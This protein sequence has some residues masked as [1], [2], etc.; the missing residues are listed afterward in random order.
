MNLK[1]V[2]LEAGH[3]NSMD[4]GQYPVTKNR[5]TIKCCKEK[6]NVYSQ[7]WGNLSA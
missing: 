1:V 5:G 2:V 4:L 6:Q 3:Q 7:H